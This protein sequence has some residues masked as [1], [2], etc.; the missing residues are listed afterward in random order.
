[1]MVSTISKQTRDF[2]E[3]NLSLAEMI[4]GLILTRQESILLEPLLAL[5]AEQFCKDNALQPPEDDVD[6]A[7]T[8]IRKTRK[9]F[10]SQETEVWLKAVNISDDE[11][12]DW[13]R[14]EVQIDMFKKSIAGIV[15]VERYFSMNR[16]KFDEVEL[17]KIVC[18]TQ[19]TA[20]ELKAQILEGESF[21]ELA[22]TYS[23][24]HATRAVCGYLG[25]LRRDKLAAELESQVFSPEVADLIGPIKVASSYHLYKVEGVFRAELNQDIEDEISELLVN[26]WLQNCLSTWLISKGFE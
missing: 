25:R 7:I 3:H 14:K 16:L 11:L 6:A 17:Y 1:M 13:A 26:D 8:E 12:R 20:R 9:L 19:G 5:I 22:R 15:S 24:D 4:N 2:L 21:F 18:K 23:T 10:T